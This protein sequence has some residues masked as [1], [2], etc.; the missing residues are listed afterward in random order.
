MKADA[1]DLSAEAM[2]AYNLKRKRSDDPMANV[3]SET[4]LEYKG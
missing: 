4:L 1:Q 2:E 3:S